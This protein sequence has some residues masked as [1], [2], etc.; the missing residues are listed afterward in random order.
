MSTNDTPYLT[1]NALFG[2]AS[3]LHA[4]ARLLR[5]AAKQLGEWLERRRV[6]AA[7]LHDFATMSERD[8]HDIGLSRSDVNRVAWGATAWRP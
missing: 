5:S 3:T 6:A 1:V 8:L 7:A 4:G 2:F